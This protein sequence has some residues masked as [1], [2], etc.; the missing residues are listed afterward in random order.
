VAAQKIPG[1]KVPA[2]I[3]NPLTVVGV[4]A[5]LAELSG[6][7]VLPKLP[8]PVQEYFIWFVMGFPALL[9]VLFFLT[10]NFNHKCLYAP[11]DYRD[12]E[13]FLAGIKQIQKDIYARADAVR[14]LALGVGR[15]VAFGL[16]GNGRITGDNLD[17]LLLRERN[18]LAATLRET[19]LDEKEVADAVSPLTSIIAFD[20]ASQVSIDTVH[21]LRRGDMSRGHPKETEVSSHVQ[22]ALLKSRRGQEIES[23]RGYLES[24]DVWNEKIQA[25]VRELAYFRETDRLHPLAEDE[26]DNE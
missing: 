15:V 8:P 24:L 11:S 5:G 26:K 14:R 12:D 18:R 17:H 16:A 10:L 19:G 9:V 22:K 23:V 25:G 6:A 1:A 21:A 13:A 20:L 3:R 4:F 7:L 2:F